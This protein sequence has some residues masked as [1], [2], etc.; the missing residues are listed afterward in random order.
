[1]VIE[2]LKEEGEELVATVAVDDEG[3]LTR[4]GKHL[5]QEA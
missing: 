5:V 4:H 1:M 3:L 2:I